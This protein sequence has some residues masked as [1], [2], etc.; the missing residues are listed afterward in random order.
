MYIATIVLL[1]LAWLYFWRRYRDPFYPAIILLPQL[2][3]LYGYMPLELQL[4]DPT[5]F[6]DFTGGDA[7]YRYQALAVLLILCLIGGIW[8]ATRR[9]SR[10]T[11]R[12]QMLELRSPDRVFLIAVAL[13]AL[14]L[15]AWLTMIL[16]VGGFAVAYGS[17]YGGGWHSSGYI[18]EFRFLGLIG[19]LLIYMARTGKGVRPVDWAIIVLCI[20]PTLTQGILGARRG[21]FFLA[22]ILLAGGYI[23]FMRKRI[24]LAVILA[25]GAAVGS[26]MLF[27]VANRGSIYLGADLG[28]E[29]RAPTEFLLRWSS[30]E[31]LIGG[32]VVKYTNTYG[33]FY[34]MRELVW[35]IARIIPS[36]AWPT[37]YQDLPSLFGVS[38]DLRLNGGVSQEGLTTIANWTPSVGSAE[39]F[40]GSLYLEFGIL[41]PVIAFLIGRFFGGLWKA[42][43][44]SLSARAIYL[45]SAALSVYLVMQALDP[46]LYRM[47]LYGVPAWLV[48]RTIRTRPMAAEVHDGGQVRSQPLNPTP[49]RRSRYAPYRSSVE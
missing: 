34:G 17:A 30:N 25:A 4:A 48:L 10:R 14:G 46:W 31:Y 40:A 47:M 37:I 5:Q 45:L 29:L 6:K 27:L 28:T 23:Y 13:G 44:I 16:N 43:K 19:A 11:T 20:T 2:A 22:M 36:A 1:A 38:V 7:V 24:S 21:P 33:P 26:I 49:R 32:A 39:G 3:F 41:A 42:A 12:W 18:R 35:L 9:L 8:S 15:A